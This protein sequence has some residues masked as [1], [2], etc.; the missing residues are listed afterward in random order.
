MKMRAVRLWLPVAIIAAGVVLI[1]ATGASELG[2]EGGAMLIAAGM[3]VWLLNWTYRLGVRGDRERDT[4][5]RARAYFDEHG[6]WP[7]EAPPPDSAAAGETAPPPAP[8]ADRHR[9][10]PPDHRHRA[11]RPPRPRA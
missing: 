1:A 11:R 3:S 5:D 6:Y 7:D 4:E 10:R 8:P 9:R 2:L